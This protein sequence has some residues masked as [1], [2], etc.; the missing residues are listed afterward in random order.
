MTKRLPPLVCCLRCLSTKRSLN[1]LI[2]P[3]NWG[4]GS[5]AQPVEGKLQG[6]RLDT[7]IR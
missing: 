7:Y 6:A 3:A 2:E 5:I 4:M 1:S